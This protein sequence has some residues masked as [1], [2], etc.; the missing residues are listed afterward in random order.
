MRFENKKNRKNILNQIGLHEEIKKIEIDTVAITERYTHRLALLLT[1]KRTKIVSKVTLFPSMVQFL[2]CIALYKDQYRYV[3]V[4]ILVYT[5]VRNFK[6]RY[7]SFIF[8]PTG[9]Q[10]MFDDKV[11]KLSSDL[12]KKKTFKGD[13]RSESEG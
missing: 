13:P 8:K 10:V 6:G 12:H 11:I 7:H 5:V 2:K 1:Q 3:P 9:Y 4:T